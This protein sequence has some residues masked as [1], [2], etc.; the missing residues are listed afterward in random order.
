MAN[1]SSKILPC[2]NAAVESLPL[3]Q[4]PTSRRFD[5][6]VSIPGVSVVIAFALIIDMPE[7]GSLE[8]GQARLLPAS[9]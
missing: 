6:L 5:I 4:F 8:N 7:L 3:R 2:D 1:Y 9:P